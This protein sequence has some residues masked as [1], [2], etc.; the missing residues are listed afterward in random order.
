MKKKCL[1]EDLWKNDRLRKMFK[2]FQINGGCI[3]YYYSKT[4]L[5]D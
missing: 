2:E 5:K 3:Q 1:Q 4:K